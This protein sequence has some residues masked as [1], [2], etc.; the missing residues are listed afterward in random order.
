MF[1]L[2]SFFT[3]PLSFLDIIMSYHNRRCQACIGMERLNITGDYLVAYC[4]KSGSCGQAIKRKEIKSQ[5]SLTHDSI[6]WWENTIT[7]SGN[8]SLQHQFVSSMTERNSED[9][10]NQDVKATNRYYQKNGGMEH[11]CTIYIWNIRHKACR[12]VHLGRRASRQVDI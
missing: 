4:L 1:V 2:P 3:I 7:P 10:T 8:L 9:T 12:Q 6:R 5:I 11:G